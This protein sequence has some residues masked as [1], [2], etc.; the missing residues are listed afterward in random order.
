M[1]KLVSWIKSGFGSNP[2]MSRQNIIPSLLFFLVILFLDYHIQTTSLSITVRL[3][4]KLIFITWTSWLVYLNYL[5]GEKINIILWLI[6][7][8]WA[9]V[10]IASLFLSGPVVQPLLLLIGAVVLF[11]SFYFLFSVLNNRK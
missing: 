10:V 6:N 1:K 4:S 3:S 8:F 9:L 7:I 2:T 5:A 11:F